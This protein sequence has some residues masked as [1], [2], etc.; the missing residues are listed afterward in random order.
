MALSR[1]QYVQNGQEGFFHCLNRCVRRAFL[2]GSDSVTGRDFSH[3]KEWLVDRLR[4]LESIFVI[5]A[6]RPL[7]M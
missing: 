3:R 2:C 7:C 5:K 4:F 1:S 6:A